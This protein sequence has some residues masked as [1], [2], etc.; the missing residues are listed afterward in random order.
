MYLYNHMYVATLTHN[1]IDTVPQTHTH[2]KEKKAKTDNVGGTR[3]RD[4]FGLCM[5]HIRVNMH[6]HTQIAEQSTNRAVFSS[7]GWCPIFKRW[8]LGG[9][10]PGY[11]GLLWGSLDSQINFCLV[12][13]LAGLG[14][15]RG[16]RLT[17]R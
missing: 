13:H 3:A 17:S 5:Q 11:P 6:T 4:V 8:F 7:M 10:V 1:T 2:M 14:R 9:C 12:F 16:L 15:A